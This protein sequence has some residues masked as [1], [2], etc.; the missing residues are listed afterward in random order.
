MWAD[1]QETGISSEPNTRNRVH[2]TTTT[3][4]TYNEYGPLVPTTFTTYW[5]TPC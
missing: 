2:G 1:C 3:L 5:N 4:L